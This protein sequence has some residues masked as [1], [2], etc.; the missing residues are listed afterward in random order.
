VT[1]DA[2]DR[3]AGEERQRAIR[4]LLERQVLFAADPELVLVRRHREEVAAALR[5]HLGASL[6]VSVDTAHLAKRVTL[7]GARPLRL[8]PRSKSERARPVD[9]HRVLAQRGC[10]LVCVIA[11]VL[12]RRGWV[13]VPLGTLADDVV[14]H[15]SSLEIELDWRARGDR[16][17]LSD[18]VDFLAGLGVLELRSGNAGELRSEGEGF[19]DVHRRR[20]ALLLIDPVR[21]AEAVAPGDLEAPEHSGGDLAGRARAQ[22]L[23][24]MLVEDPVVYLDDLDEESRIYFV[25]QRARLERIAAALTGLQVERRQ[26]GTA[27][28][29]RGRELTDR[30]FPAGGHLKQLALLML[31]ELCRRDR[32]D[33]TTV[34]RADVL[35]V[36]RDLLRAHAG[37]WSWDPGDAVTVQ[38]TADEALAVLSDLRLLAVSDAGVRVLPGAHRYRGATARR[39][40]VDQLELA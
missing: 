8:A 35:R 6:S 4:A 3:A 20:L 17:A 21:C 22:R 13:Q 1:L 7:A 18:A 28:V 26:E 40:T 38:R 9:E 30:P 34:A 39:R 11:A 10:L 32:A 36:V 29:S 25:A 16:L 5:D 37:S 2:L 31:P 15:A 12:E 27:L 33:G 14:A 19:Y 23:L 24:R